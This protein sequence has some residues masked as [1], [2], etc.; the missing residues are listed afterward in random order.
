[1]VYSEAMLVLH[2]T[3]PMGADQVISLLTELKVGRGPHNDLVLPYD[4]VSWSHLVFRVVSARVM[5][6][7]L[8]S[9]NGT[10]LDGARIVHPTPL[11]AG[12]SVTVGNCTFHVDGT[13]ASPSSGMLFIEDQ[14]TGVCFPLREPRFVLGD[15][16]DSDFRFSGERVEIL[17]LDGVATVDG[18]PLDLPWRGSLSGRQVRI[19]SDGREWTP[20]LSDTAEL[21]RRVLRVGLEPPMARLTDIQVGKSHTVRAPNRVNLLY[22]LA[23]AVVADRR[24]GLAEERCGWRTDE[25]VTIGVWGRGGLDSSRNRLNTLLYRLRA[26]FAENGLADE[27]VAKDAG[28]TRLESVKIDFEAN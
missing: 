5:V 25:A 24:E 22:F 7:D 21:P 27:L 28:W 17:V 2:L 13:G 14:V 1:M 10:F 6:E 15:A 9:R 23:A 18:T 8:G 20:T 16:E 11:R 12:S 3:T 19:T 4:E 26:E